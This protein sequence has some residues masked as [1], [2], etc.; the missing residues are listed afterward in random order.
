MSPSSGRGTADFRTHYFF[1]GERPYVQSAVQTKELFRYLEHLRT[2]GDLPADG[3]VR[4]DLVKY[5]EEV[6]FDGRFVLTPLDGPDDMP[7][8][9]S[10]FVMNLSI[11]EK[12]FLAHFEPDDDA[13][14]RENRKGGE[15]TAF[16]SD[17]VIDQPF[18][19]RARVQVP[20]AGADLLR[21]IIAFVREILLGSLGPTEKVRCAFIRDWQVAEAFLPRGPRTGGDLKVHCQ[22]RRM[23]QAKDRAAF[24]FQVGL[25]S[26]PT[27]AGDHEGQLVICFYAWPA[28]S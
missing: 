27:M 6:T 14:V 10:A 9:D 15:S 2:A 28:V 20:D 5:R 22:G 7:T 21:G 17:F 1:E 26:G 12:A 8:P 3:A 13:P 25:E 23:M 11:G 4:L 24:V 19:G 18:H 16:L